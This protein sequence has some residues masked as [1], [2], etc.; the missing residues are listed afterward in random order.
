MQNLR[1]HELR[2]KQLSFLFYFCFWMALLLTVACKV[3]PEQPPTKVSIPPTATNRALSASEVS[4]TTIITNPTPKAATPPPATA[5][6]PTSTTTPEPSATIRPYPTLDFT[7]A[8]P[9][10]AVPSP[11]P[12]FAKPDYVTNIVLLGNDV[13]YAQGGRTDSIIIVSINRQLKTAVLLTLPRDLYVVIPGWKMTRINLALPH[14]H[15]VNYPGGGG[16]LIKDTIE[17]NLGIPIDYYARIGFD[18]FQQVVDALG[19]VEIVNNCSLTDWRLSAPDLDPELEENW[20]QFTLEPGVHEM[21]GDLALWY[22]RSRRTTNDFERGQRQ[23]QLLRA[24]FEKGLR[25]DLLPEL[26]QLWQTYQETIETDMSLSLLLELAALAPSVQENG[27][28]HLVLAGESV[29]AWREPG[30]GAAVQLLQWSEASATLARVM[31]PPILNRA[32]RP[33]LSVEVVTD[34]FIMY[35]QMAHNLAWYG[36][37]PVWSELNEPLPARTRIEYFAP[38]FKE[39]YDWLLSWLFHRQ[40]EDILLRPATTEQV[41]TYRV[42]LGSDANPCL[43][44]L[45]VPSAPGD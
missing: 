32:N 17:Y 19:G 23:Q 36:F 24:M 16:G 29:Q 21:D 14:G 11:V 45:E 20:E 27:I 4:P 42:T 15:G 10:T 22:A 18:G 31:Q 13:K 28:Q 40:P 35:R 2:M 8:T 12:P 30:S 9:A 6:S 5:V 3:P 7:V 1:Q 43:A 34:D 39:S 41:N 37:V 38:N 25:L 33:P 44:Q 26:P